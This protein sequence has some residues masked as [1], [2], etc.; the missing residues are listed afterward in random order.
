MWRVIFF[1]LN[2]SLKVYSQIDF[3][4]GDLEPPCNCEGSHCECCLS[5]DL[6]GQ[7]GNLSFVNK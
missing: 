6:I 5:I 2:F 7:E 4:F 1:L 3:D